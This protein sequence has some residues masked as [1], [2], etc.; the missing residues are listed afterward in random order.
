M[1]QT[2][3]AEIR[4]EAAS[5]A[6]SSPGRSTEGLWVPDAVAPE[7]PEE[8]AAAGSVPFGRALSKTERQDALAGLG[9]RSAAT[10]TPGAAELPPEEEDAGGLREELALRRVLE[11]VRLVFLGYLDRV[12]GIGSGTDAQEGG[13][14]RV[15]YRAN[16]TCRPYRV[17]L[18][19]LRTE[20][21]F[22]V[23]VDAVGTPRLAHG[24]GAR[25]H[26]P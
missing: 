4:V 24:D 26:R 9:L 15:R 21:R 3:G 23:S 11:G 10:G 6:E 25:G 14:A 2:D 7:R 12:D 1:L 18:M 22:E 19:G 5:A 17:V 16:G 8:P 20:E 13:V